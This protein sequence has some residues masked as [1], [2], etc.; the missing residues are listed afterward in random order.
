VDR[1]D[2]KPFYKHKVCKKC[3]KFF[4]KTHT[5]Q[6]LCSKSCGD[7]DQKEKED[8]DFSD[9]LPVRRGAKYI[10]I[11]DCGC[12]EMEKTHNMVSTYKDEKRT[13]FLW[14]KVGHFKRVIKRERSTHLELIGVVNKAIRNTM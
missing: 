9:V 2:F 10:R 6:K 7:T 14:F 13:G 12:G 11:C 8:S 5:G 3:G 1:V 4:E